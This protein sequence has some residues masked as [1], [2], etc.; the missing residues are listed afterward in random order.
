MTIKH[1]DSTAVIAMI[2]EEPSSKAMIPSGVVKKKVAMSAS[3]T[4]AAPVRE[5][6]RR[7]NSIVAGVSTAKPNAL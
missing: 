7:R 1:A 3:A 2:T 4:T 6:I 5:I